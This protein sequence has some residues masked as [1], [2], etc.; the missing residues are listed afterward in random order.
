MQHL[1]LCNNDILLMQ[2]IIL[3]NNHK[4]PMDCG[5]FHMTHDITILLSQM[6]VMYIAID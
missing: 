4:I 2:Y 6:P 3:D 1:T 5:K